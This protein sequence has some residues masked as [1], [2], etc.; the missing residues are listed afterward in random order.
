MPI[1]IKYK[2]ACFSKGGKCM[3]KTILIGSVAL[4]M[5]T[6]LYSCASKNNKIVSIGDVGGVPEFFLNPPLSD[7][8]IYGVGTAKTAR[9]DLSRKMAIA[10]ARDDIAF[11]L[12]SQVESA[13]IDYAQES[14]SDNNS[15]LLSFSETVSRQI[16]DQ[17]LQGTRTEKIIAGEDGTLY[18]LVSFPKANILKTADEIFSRNEDAAFA[19]FKAREALDYLDKTLTEKKTV[20]GQNSISTKE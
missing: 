1:I 19:E 7:S 6:I 14:G 2:N 17:T 9:L 8:V 18:A 15:Q 11:Q 16:A 10:R 5:V 12:Q 3:K 13:I 20:A 4:A